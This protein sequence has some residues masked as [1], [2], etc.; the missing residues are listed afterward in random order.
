MERHVHSAAGSENYYLA[1]QPIFDV[2]GHV[3]G[4][5][6]LFRDSPTAVQAMV[7]DP[8]MATVF[9]MTCGFLNPSGDLE[10]P[11]KLFI[12]FTDRLI[13]G[14]APL[15]LPSS[16]IV[17]ELLENAVLS[18][19]LYDALLE[20]K[21]QGYSIAI[22][23]YTGDTSL[24]EYIRI[25]DIIKVDVL[26]MDRSKL[27]FLAKKLS[28]TGAILLA[29]RVEKQSEF[30]FLKQLGF[31]M[32]Q[33]YYFCRPENINGKKISSQHHTRLSA[34][35]AIEDQDFDIYECLKLFKEDV[36]LSYRLLRLLNSPAFSFATEIKSIR[37]AITLIGQE[38]LKHWLRIVII[39]DMNS[40]AASEEIC[41]VSICRAIFMESLA[42]NK[43]LNGADP[44]ELFL[45]GLFS[46]LDALLETPMET[47]IEHLPLSPALKHGYFTE[48]SPYFK[49]LLFTIAMEHADWETV[50]TL[51]QELTLDTKLA[52]T[53]YQDALIQSIHVTFGLR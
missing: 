28:K 40:K 18:A 51:A 47:I 36:S 9:V 5:E 17:V 25:A 10:N 3:Q 43:Q 12:N 20:L 11:H 41:N 30:E 48:P 50:D 33:G 19:D 53:L 39:S 21:E 31:K 45:F 13:M 16:A 22:D 15:A 32:F 24:D 2:E 27:Q 34:L 29:E 49:I 37:H 6:L 38:R 4:Y 44:G 8:D 23:D 52:R 35:K 26:G 14:K 46:L 42:E 1:R 7:D